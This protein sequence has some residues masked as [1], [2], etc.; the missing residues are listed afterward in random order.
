[1]IDTYIDWAAHWPQAA[2][3]LQILL[4][5]TVRGS[6]SYTSEGAAQQRVRLA[7]A[8]AGALCWRNN[9]GATPAKCSNCGVK[10]QP[11][12]YGLANDSPQVNE[13]I[14]SADLILAIPRV[15]TYDMVGKTIAQFGSIE[16]KAPGWV[17]T[18]KEQE[19]GQIAWAALIASKGGYAV[20]ST[21]EIE[22]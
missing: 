21:G 4:S 10:R 3:E 19:P 16:V 9:V 11:V 7:A 17:Y 2:A 14:K 6:A 13:G 5:S 18:G 15:I 12:R 8:K 1:M 20:F 22:L